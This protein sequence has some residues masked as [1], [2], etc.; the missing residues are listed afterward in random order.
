MWIIIFQFVSLIFIQQGTPLENNKTPE[1][2][3]MS[4]D[5]FF[6][7]QAELNSPVWGQR[8]FRRGQSSSP[9]AV[10]MQSGYLPPKLTSV[11]A[12]YNFESKTRCLLG[13]ESVSIH[14]W[15]SAT[16]SLREPSVHMGLLSLTF[17]RDSSSFL[18]WFLPEYSWFR[19]L[20]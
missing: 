19:R 1:I 6:R 4:V 3:D 11:S 14:N 2:K 9:L 5:V 8:W 18:N 17:S 7:V 15:C 16:E 12:K 10:Q 13:G 20:C